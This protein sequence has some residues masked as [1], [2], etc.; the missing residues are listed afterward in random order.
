MMNDYTSKY[1]F[2]EIADKYHIS[3]TTLI[4]L[5]D[6]ILCIDEI[7]FSRK[8]EYKYVCVLVDYKSKTIYDII[9]SRQLPYLIKYFSRFSQKQ[10]DMVSFFI[11]DMYDSYACIK[12][13][14]FKKA[15]HII[16][17]FHVISQMTNVVHILR[18]RAMNRFTD[19]ESKEYNFM[20]THWKLFLT[21]FNKIPDKFYTHKASQVMFHYDEMVTHCIQLNSDLWTAYNCLQDLYKYLRF[22]SYSEAD[23]FIPWIVKRLID[24]Y[25]DDLVKVSHTFL[26]WKPGICSSFA[27]N[28]NNIYY[29]NAIAES[30]NNQLATVLKS[31][32]GYP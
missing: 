3:T 1:T 11:S 21:N 13:K 25:N 22:Y 19:K 31:A 30:M 32:Y 7:Y 10:L 14:F 27:K 8:A 18:T 16:D 4:K 15:T 29:T 2:Q 17:L 24:S 5:F 12:N 23:K 9:P 6:E 28:Q 20:K 26:K